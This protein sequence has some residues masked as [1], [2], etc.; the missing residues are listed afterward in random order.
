[1]LVS[2]LAAGQAGA[3]SPSPEPG[4]IQLA[5][6][7]LGHAG[8]VLYVAAHPDDENTRLIAWLVGDRKLDVAYVSLTRG[9]GGQNLVGPELGPLLGLIRTEELLAA[10]ALDGARQFFTRAVDFGYSKTAEE[11]LGKWGG[12]AVLADLVRVYR[13]FRPDVVVTRF[14]TTPPNHGHHT[15]SAL[16]AREAVDAAADPS[17][18]PD[19]LTTLRPHRVARLVENKSHWRFK[20]DEDL[21]RYHRVDVGTYS[22]LLGRSYG[23][24]SAASR[25]MH[26]SQGFGTAP[27]VGPALE[28]FEPLVGLAPEPGGDPFAGIDWT[29]ARFPNTG[30]LRAAIAR[31]AE[32][33]T[34]S[35]PERSVPALLAVR[36]TLAALPDTNPF[37]ASKLADVDALLVA[38]AGLVLDARA[39][40]HGVSPGEAVKVT[41]TA[42]SRTSGAFALREV[43]FFDGHVSA[44]G[45]LA[46]HTPTRFEH[47]AAP[48]A[49]APP[50]TPPW[51]RAPPDGGLY[52]VPRPE[53]AILPDDA[54]D[55]TVAFTL[56]VAA[57]GAPPATLTV[58]RPVLHARV[59]PVHGERLRPV[60]VTPP[61]TIDPTRPVLMLP[62]GEPG[63]LTATIT[64]HGRARAGV[65]RVDAPAGWRV[66]P[67]TVDFAIDAALG[68]ASASFTVTP[69]RGATDPANLT[70]VARVDGRD[71]A[72]SRD[73]LDYVHIPERSVARPSTVRAV[74]LALARRGDRIGYIPGAGDGVAESLAQ[75][76]YDVTVLDDAALA[77]GHLGR[78]DAI[79]AGIRAYNVDPSLR[80][81][82]Q[83]LMDYVAAGGRFV[84]QYVVSTRWRPLGD[85]PIG[86]WP[87]DISRERVTDE[88]AELR[89][90]DPQH[91][92]LTTPNRLV[93]ADFDGWVQ[94]RGL[95][96]ADGWDPRYQTVL[97]AN[98]PGEGPLRGGLLVAPHGRGTFVYTGL[99]FF[100]QLPEGV[101]GAYRLFANLL[102]LR[103][104]TGATR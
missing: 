87:F 79:V 2:I 37:K 41:A 12:D 4:R 5:L 47:E 80:N 85:V 83:R 71:V 21:T 103:A 59:D 90:V 58:T 1:M 30:D 98:D 68:E 102:A 8:R 50:S 29:W 42:L 64:A 60:E 45:P 97:E 24:I 69:P 44:G 23:E 54:P 27:S 49:D 39:D 66:T 65:L 17:R 7:R 48:T 92:A 91:P 57:A 13:T 62:N 53:L 38:C 16:L 3:S 56:D 61:V 76:G 95:Y 100:R 99:A 84:V 82:H 33:F 31:A 72:W 43:R 96:F 28:Y 52:R 81:H 10:R 51:L 34:P 6:E 20:P 22:P 77:R 67:A 35:H 40:A 75:V 9:D 14:S 46:P 55:L 88:T 18:F 104:P 89:P 78:F 73:T 25:T 86:P 74:P 32:G 15:A 19:Q 26:K 63:A 94:E 93:A 11:T 101:P 70:L 36:A